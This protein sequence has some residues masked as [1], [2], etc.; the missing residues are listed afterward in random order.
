MNIRDL[1][2]TDEQVAHIIQHEGDLLDREQATELFS[3][4]VKV[5]PEQVPPGIAPVEK[6]I[7][8]TRLAFLMGFEKAMSVMQEAIKEALTPTADQ[9]QG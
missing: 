6:M 8:M 3:E 5:L 4:I 2:L 7:Y 1:L 9:S